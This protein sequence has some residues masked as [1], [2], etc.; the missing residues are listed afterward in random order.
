MGYN[1]YNS[2]SISHVQ[3]ILCVNWRLVGV[4]SLFLYN[5]FRHTNVVKYKCNHFLTNTTRQLDFN[6][7][8]I[9]LN[10]IR[11]RDY[12]FVKNQK[13]LCVLIWSYTLGH[14]HNV[15]HWHNAGHWH[16]A[17]RWHYVGHDTIGHWHNTG[18]WHNVSR[19]HYVGHWHNLGHWHNAG[20]WP[21]TGCWHNTGRWPNAGC[22][23]NAGHWHTAGQWH[24][25]GYL[26]SLHCHCQ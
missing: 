9:K 23:H 24:N 15:G 22:W 12:D 11:T 3:R 17:R 16:S 8:F 20:H 19:W 1:N 26:H 7:L 5:K 18:H 2:L 21:N 4:V 13:K 14:W 25:A 6:D 10:F